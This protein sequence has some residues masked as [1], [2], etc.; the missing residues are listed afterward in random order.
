MHISNL[1][2]YAMIGS[3]TLLWFDFFL[4]FTTEVERIW[5]RKFTGATLLFLVLR[6]AS[7]LQ[8][9]LDCI[10]SFWSTSRDVPVYWALYRMTQV[11]YTLTYLMSALITILRV[12]GVSVRDWRLVG[13]VTP[14]A[15]ATPA[16][17][18]ITYV[19][20]EV[21]V[22]LM[23]KMSESNLFL[24]CVTWYKTFSIKRHGREAGLSMPLTTLLIKDGSLF[25]VVLVAN[26]I[27]KFASNIL[28]ISQPQFSIFLVWTYFNNTTFPAIIL[29]RFML[30]LRSVYLWNGVGKGG[31][32]NE[33]QGYDSV[34]LKGL[35]QITSVRVVGNLAATIAR[36]RVEESSS[37]E[38][39]ENGNG[40]LPWTATG[41]EGDMDLRIVQYSRD[42][43]RD[44][45]LED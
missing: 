6:Y 42:P 26:L 37:W 18:I 22:L 27:I 3:T 44:G 4:T 35:S 33:S 34:V 43:F 11:C 21:D 28:L 2:K 41:Q 19:L 15:F 38:D 5:R 1:P 16:S 24:I 7:L 45:I 25:F 39:K 32:W 12:Y 9:L 20:I 36:G 31:R 23:V 40:A 29:T 14:L 13:I 8:S 17:Y 30:N 10:E